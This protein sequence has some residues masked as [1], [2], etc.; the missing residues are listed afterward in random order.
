MISGFSGA[1]LHKKSTE[2]EISRKMSYLA[3]IF[4]AGL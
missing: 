2:K 1:N 3:L 4:K